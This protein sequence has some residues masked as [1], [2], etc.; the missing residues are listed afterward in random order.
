MY[1]ERRNTFAVPVDNSGETSAGRATR[2]GFI[3]QGQLA[4]LRRWIGPGAV[5]A[6]AFDAPV[7]WTAASNEN[8]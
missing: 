2:V 5:R 4:K 1:Q 6:T 8:C 3:D 7:A